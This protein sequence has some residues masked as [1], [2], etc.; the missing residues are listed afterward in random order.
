M[1]RF[2]IA[3]AP[4]DGNLAQLQR[5]INRLFAEILGHVGPIGEDAGMT[6]APRMNVS[7]T[8]QE[9]LID[10]ELP[11]VP[12]HE[13]QVD[14]TDDLLTVRGARS[15]GQQDAQRHVSEWSSCSFARAIR[16]PFAPRPD[17]V[18]A[19]FEH[20]MLH[21]ALPKSGSRS[22]VHRIPIQSAG[23]PAAAGKQGCFGT[24]AALAGHPTATTTRLDAAGADAAA[25]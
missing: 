23:T 6:R 11:G 21:I 18:R 22:G 12:E 5:E 16:L 13:L 4:D 7:E 10:V 8:G 9:L 25:R 15:A 14:L 17:S 20:G 2:P 19:V 1:A 3:Y 24:E